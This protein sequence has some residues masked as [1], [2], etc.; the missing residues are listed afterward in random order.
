MSTIK[1]KN[2]G[3][4]KEGF[5]DSDGNEWMDVKKV[6]VFIGNQGS[7]KSV[8]AK[9]I[10]TFMWIE[11]ALTRGDYDRKWFSRK[12]KLRNQ[13]L[14]YFRIENYFPESDNQS[15]TFIE[16]R[17]ESF[18]IIFKNGLLHIEDAKNGDYPLPQIMYVPAERNFTAD[19]KS[20]KLIKLTSES[21]IEFVTEMTKALLDMKGLVRL[22]INDVDVEYNKQF[23]IIYIRGKVKEDAYRIKL[24]EASSGFQSLV[25]LYL[26]SMFLANSVKTQSDS[27]KEAMTSEQRERFRKRVQA[28]NEN[29]DLT[30]ELRR[31][32]ISELAKEFTKT[33]FINIVEEPEQ[34]LFPS[35][36]H[37]ILNSL[38]EFNNMNK[39]NKLIMTTH[40]PYLINYL[41]LGVKAY[42]LKEKLITEELKNR[43]NKIVPLNSTVNPNDLVIYELDEADGTIKKLGNF[44]GIP[45]DKNL[46]NKSLGK[47]NQLYDSLLEI[48]EE[49]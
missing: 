34:N 21:M 36:Q 46:L 41:T 11:K 23:D 33:A 26:V 45:S 29:S 16:Y 38:L 28:I 32:A 5:K 30:D 27:T 39:G 12:N 10:T 18:N 20:P 37:K 15:K 6:T 19:V 13:F 1:I 3:P 44:E 35:S 25:P 31:I 42:E 43:M 7:G 40:S 14:S 24:S 4:I 2:F 48:E 8:T 9:L 17:G 22:P 47:A 49:L